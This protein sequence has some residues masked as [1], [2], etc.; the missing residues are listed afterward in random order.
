M[1]VPG[2]PELMLL[3]AR[4][5]SSHLQMLLLEIQ[6]YNYMLVEKPLEEYLLA[7]PDLDLGESIS[8]NFKTMT[9]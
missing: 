8:V 5:M 3:C 1:C 4:A 6:C 7:W 2:M 9:T